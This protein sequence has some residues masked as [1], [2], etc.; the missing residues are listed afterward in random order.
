MSIYIETNYKDNWSLY[1]SF[2][3]EEIETF[4][5]EEDLLKYLMLD[6]VRHAKL[7][8]IKLFYLRLYGYIVNEERKMGYPRHSD[9]KEYC[10]WYERISKMEDEQQ[11]NDEIDK[12]FMSI[13][14]SG[15]GYNPELEK[16]EYYLGICEK[17]G[18]LYN[19][20]VK[21]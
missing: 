13:L 15:C 1:S 10:D 20:R 11:Y 2:L 9:Y 4:T 18:N 12:M 17:C 5:N 7:D 8:A 6:K 19:Q 16:E 3:D 21:K 14:E